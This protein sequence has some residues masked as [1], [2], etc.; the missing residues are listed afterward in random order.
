MYERCSINNFI[1]SNI[2]IIISNIN[3]IIII[4]IINYFYIIS[5]SYDSMNWWS[6][7]DKS[8]NV[9]IDMKQLQL[10]SIQYSVN[11]SERLWIY[12][13]A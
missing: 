5:D 3:I 1:I 12:S 11:N 13:S 4:I 9:F 10:L 7:L 2:I 8:R 6:T